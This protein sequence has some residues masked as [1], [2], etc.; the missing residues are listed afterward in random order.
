MK[1]T[2]CNSTNII[3]DATRGDTVCGS[4]GQVLEESEVVFDVA[5]ED[6]KVV[7]TFVN[8]NYA[9]GSFG[10]SKGS[11]M[12]D[13]SVIR[14]NKAYKL[15]SHIASRLQINSYL[16]D[17]AKRIYK[18]A[19]SKKFVQGRKTKNVIAAILYAVCRLEKT[20]HMLLDFSDVLQTNFY[21]LGAI[22]LKLIRNLQIKVP[23]VDPTLFIHRYCAKL[24][25]NEK[26]KGVANVAL[27]LIQA[28][29]RDWI[30][31][32]RRPSG[33]CGAAILI[34]ARYNGFK[35]SIKQ[36]ADAVN[37]CEETIRVRLDEFSKTSTARMTRAEFD[38]MSISTEDKGMDP[39]SFTKSIIE[40]SQEELFSNKST[41]DGTK[42]STKKSKFE[43]LITED[44]FK[45]PG[46][47]PSH[48]NNITTTVHTNVNNTNFMFED[49][50]KF[51]ASN[52]IQSN[53]QFVNI[54][55][56][57]ETF[58]PEIEKIS[59][60]NMVIEEELSD[61]E[62]EDKYFVSDDEYKL[63]KILWEVV[64]KEWIEDQLNKEELKKNEAKK[65]PRKTS[66]E[67][68]TVC[69]TP[70]EAIQKSN[71]FGRKL[72]YKHIENIFNKK[73]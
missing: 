53:Q 28:M 24:E 44:S 50:K 39:P 34:S 16:V 22:Y 61:L 11:M 25:F 52:F 60:N 29:N 20:R 1:C 62:E 26:A 30:I 45:R 6:T 5:F 46:N 40:K 14:L 71:K 64:F 57:E 10:K 69:K 15:I 67:S 38:V 27:K 12:L 65:R 73:N 13:S 70:V 18:L 54:P 4:C 32:G 59:Q 7:G 19:S 42:A 3:K 17:M 33:L 8:E 21:V 68:Y 48:T 47:V 63:K 55:N 36:I 2:R 58:L 35:R 72:N 51:F 43:K 41:K 37:V 49:T 31:T 9:G 56:I 66:K 23:I